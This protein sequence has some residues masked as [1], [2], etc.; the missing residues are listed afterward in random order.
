MWVDVNTLLGHDIMG[1]Y[2][3]IMPSVIISGDYKIG[4]ESII[5]FGAV[6]HQ[7]ILIGKE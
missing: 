6:I 7:N 4:S 2:I 5:L 1:N 3:S